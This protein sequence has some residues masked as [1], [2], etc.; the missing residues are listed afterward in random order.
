[1]K[2]RGK[3][4]ARRPWLMTPNKDQGLKGRNMHAPN[5]ALSGLDSID[6]FY[7]GRRA[8]R[9]PLAF[10]YRAFG[11]AALSALGASKALLSGELFDLGG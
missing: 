7:Q 11:A 8:S 4:E 10:I 9:L 6:C 5:F 3:C 2:A 1:M